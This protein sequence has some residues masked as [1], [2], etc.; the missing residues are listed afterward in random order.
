VELCDARGP[1]G[2]YRK[3]SAFRVSGRILPRHVHVSAHWVSKSGS[4]LTNQATVREEAQNFETNP[5]EAWLR[6]IFELANV[7]YGRIDYGVA[8]GE[9][10]V[11]EINTN[12]TLG[13]NPRR[14]PKPG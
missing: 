6:H 12:P 9:L 3:Y 10:Q 7:E 4:S 1:D 5:H 8:N 11:W 13:R 2:L 14:A